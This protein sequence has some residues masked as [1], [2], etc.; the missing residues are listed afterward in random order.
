[1]L[2]IQYIQCKHVHVPPCVFVHLFIL[3]DKGLKGLKG[4]KES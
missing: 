4:L 2:N 1:M 3:Q